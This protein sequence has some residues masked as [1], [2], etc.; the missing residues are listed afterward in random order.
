MCVD[1]GRS[2]SELDD[3][4]RLRRPLCGMLRGV[5]GREFV[6]SL[7]VCRLEESSA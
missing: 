1:D 4:H 3:I 5:Q 6:L 2:G 7:M